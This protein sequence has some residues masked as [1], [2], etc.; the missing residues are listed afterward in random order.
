MNK[1]L[2]KIIARE[3]LV[4]LGI[5]GIS[6]L[7]FL[8]SDKYPLYKFDP[9]ISSK[10]TYLDNE[11]TRVKF[12]DGTMIEF[13]TKP[14][15][16]DIQEAYSKAVGSKPS[17]LTSEQ[18]DKLKKSGFTSEQIVSF[19]LKRQT[20]KRLKIK[21]DLSSLGFLILFLGYPIYLLIRFIIWAIKVLREK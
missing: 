18:F 20:E 3:G 11:E 15:P 4:I 17:T 13:E 5:I 7:I 6:C 9:N 19:E 21:K 16:Q 2:K 10:I 1:N 12:E 8:I 14:S